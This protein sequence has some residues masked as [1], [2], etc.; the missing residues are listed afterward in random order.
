M[1]S[2]FVGLPLDYKPAG[3]LVLHFVYEW[4]ASLVVGITKITNTA[5]FIKIKSQNGLYAGFK[6][7]WVGLGRRK[8]DD[9]RP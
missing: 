7:L 2:K 5:K 1:F 4:N 9:V 3:L 6:R 8:G